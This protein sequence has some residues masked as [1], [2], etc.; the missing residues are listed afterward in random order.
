SETDT[1]VVAQLLDHNNRDC[2]NFIDAIH[3]LLHAVDG[4]NPLGI[5]CA[6]Y[7]DRRVAARR[8]PLFCWRAWSAWNT[9]A[10]TPPVW[11]CAATAC[12]G[13]ARKRAGSRCCGR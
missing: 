10:M 12:C 7:P 6:D 5:I 1:E 8:P 9:G 11:P 13:S 3:R 2:G 4:A